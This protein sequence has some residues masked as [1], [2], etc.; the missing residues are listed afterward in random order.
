MNK[1]ERAR[2]VAKRPLAAELMLDLVAQREQ[3]P[4]GE[5]RFD[6]HD[7]VEIVVTARV[8]R[9]S[10]IQARLGEHGDGVLLC[11][12]HHCVFQGLARVP[13]IRAEAEISNRHG[14][15]SCNYRSTASANAASV[16]V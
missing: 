6:F 10:A 3:M 11:E 8:D 15:T 14:I 13:E 7:A 2:C 4:H 5:S 12:A 9:G 16:F 1:I